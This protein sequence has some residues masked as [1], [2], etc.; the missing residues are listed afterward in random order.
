MDPKIEFLA[1]LGKSSAFVKTLPTWK[2]TVW[3][4]R[5][6]ASPKIA[7]PNLTAKKTPEQK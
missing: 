1:G 5:L 6:P 3:D 4:P 7:P 2:Q